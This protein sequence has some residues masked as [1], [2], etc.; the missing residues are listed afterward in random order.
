MTSGKL[1]LTAVLAFTALPAMAD[2][3][4]NGEKGYN[5]VNY[6]HRNPTAGGFVSYNAFVDDT[7]DVYIAPTA[8]VC[9][10]SRI[11][12]NVRIYG[13][14]V[15]DGATISGRAEVFGNARVSDGAEVSDN[16]RIS[17]NAEVSGS[18]RIYG[19][20]VIAGNAKIYNNT[21]DNLVQIYDNA[22]VSGNALITDNA[23]VFGNARIFANA[24]IS[25]DASISGN[26]IIN[27]HTKLNSGS[28]SSGTRTDPDY[29]GIAKAKREAEAEEARL[30]ADKIARENLQVQ[31][32]IKVGRLEKIIKEINEGAYLGVESETNT[33]TL[34][35]NSLCKLET[36]YREVTAK[37]EISRKYD[38]TFTLKMN[39]SEN[40]TF[41]SGRTIGG[42]N[43]VNA[44][45]RGIGNGTSERSY[46]DND[47]GREGYAMGMSCMGARY[48]S[49]EDTAYVA[50]LLNEMVSICKTL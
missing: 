47:T 45:L 15:I 2:L 30:R 1:L 35:R 18:V 21:Q 40:I 42:R 19:K 9:G 43:C 28:I 10:S 34:S 6:K 46:F 25:G 4:C 17:E 37:S 26:A 16:A 50:K 33:T 22:R 44:D 48:A 20:T 39:L 7:D 32:N 5:Y 23:T 38:Q 27:G 3:P 31:R 36:R 13:T 24:K 29:D 14:A 11:N 8:T 49:E 41:S 12:E